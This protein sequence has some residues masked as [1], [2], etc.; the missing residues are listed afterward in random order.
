LNRSL[1]DPMIAVQQGFF[2]FF[3]EFLRRLAEGSG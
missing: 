1:G 3:F 2:G